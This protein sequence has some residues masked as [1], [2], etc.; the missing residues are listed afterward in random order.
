MNQVLRAPA[1]AYSPEELR[2][3]L[4]SGLMSFPLTDFDAA[5]EFHEKGYRDRLDWLMPYAATALF[6]AGEG[7]R[8]LSTLDDL[9]ALADWARCG[10]G[11]E[12]VLDLSARRTRR[13]L[14]GFDR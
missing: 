11:S 3:V 7:G 12:T 2:E 13:I 9:T 14:I 8:H 1:R 4:S 6:A 10:K 5:G